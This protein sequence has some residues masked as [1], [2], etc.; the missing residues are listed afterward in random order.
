MAGACTKDR[1]SKILGALTTGNKMNRYVLLRIVYCVP[2]PEHNSHRLAFA[3][4]EDLQKKVEGLR[5]RVHE[6]EDALG[7][8]QSTITDHPHPLLAGAPA[9]NPVSDSPISSNGAAP[10]PTLTKE[11]EEFIDAFGECAIFEIVSLTLMLVHQG[12]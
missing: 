4:A 5:A 11:D 3:D 6:L 1:I 7:T 2:P 8:L 10:C 9:V 12:R